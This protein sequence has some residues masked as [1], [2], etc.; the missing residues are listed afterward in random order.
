MRIVMGAQGGPSRVL[1]RRYGEP[2]AQPLSPEE[3]LE[4]E[5]GQATRHEYVNGYV[6]AMSGVSRRHSRITMN[7]AVTLRPSATERG[8][9]IHQAEVK[10][11]LDKIFW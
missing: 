3:Y 2:G 5:H 11:A 7:I 4:W 9:R 1:N 8:C 6:Y 10:L